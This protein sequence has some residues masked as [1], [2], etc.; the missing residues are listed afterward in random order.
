MQDKWQFSTA[1]IIANTVQR[2]NGYVMERY[3]EG[4]N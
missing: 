1:Y 3:D 2:Y 4:A